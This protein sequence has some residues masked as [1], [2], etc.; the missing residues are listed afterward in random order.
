M[1]L[2]F[3]ESLPHDEGLSIRVDTLVREFAEIN[4]IFEK[5]VNFLQKISFSATVGTAAFGVY[6]SAS[7]VQLAFAGK[8]QLAVLAE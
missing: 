2:Q 8:L 6:G 4:T 5:F 3:R 7:V 1:D